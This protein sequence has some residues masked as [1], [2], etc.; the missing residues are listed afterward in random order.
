MKSNLI[1]TYPHKYF[2]KEFN[3]QGNILRHDLEEGTSGICVVK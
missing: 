1:A 3:Q 2:P